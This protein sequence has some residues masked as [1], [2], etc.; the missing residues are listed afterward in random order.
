MVD[1]SAAVA[2]AQV[3][4]HYPTGFAEA[5]GHLEKLDERLRRQTTR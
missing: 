5:G 1:E 4:K 2:V 3:I